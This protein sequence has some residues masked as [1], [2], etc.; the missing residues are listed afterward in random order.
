MHRNIHLYK[1]SKYTPKF[2][3][4]RLRHPP[5]TINLAYHP[6]NPKIAHDDGERPRVWFQGKLNGVLTPS[7][8]NIRKGVE[9]GTWRTC[10]ACKHVLFRGSGHHAKPHLS[11]T[12]KSTD[13]S[14]SRSI[15]VSTL[16]CICAIRID[17][18]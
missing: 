16:H 17:K 2:V 5:H 13:P 6:G 11:P 18:D 15:F 7:G 10:V 4:I 14:L 12:D 3:W 9:G 1:S 8:W